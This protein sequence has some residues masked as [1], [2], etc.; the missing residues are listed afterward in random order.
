M[1][2]TPRE[3]TEAWE[4]E[5]LLFHDAEVDVEEGEDGVRLTARAHGERYDPE[6]HPVKVLIK[7]ITWH[8]LTVERSGDRWRGRVIFDI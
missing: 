5:R 2:R 6:R 1:P 4:V 7:G 8:A 3:V